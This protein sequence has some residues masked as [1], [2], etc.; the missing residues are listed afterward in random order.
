MQVA[1]PAGRV[2]RVSCVC[3]SRRS[4]VVAS[5][6]LWLATAQTQVRQQ[7]VKGTQQI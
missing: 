4:Q 6:S 2:V 1:G 5:R 3:G 7:R